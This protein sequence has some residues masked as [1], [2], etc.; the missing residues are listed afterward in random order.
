MPKAKNPRHGS[1]QVW[2]RKRAS[3]QYGRVRSWKI[4]GE[5][6][7]GFAG[8]KAGMTHVIATDADKHSLTKGEDIF[9]PATILECP[10][11]K[12][13]SVRS[14]TQ[15]FYGLHVANEV[16]VGK[17]K[18]LARKIGT[19]KAHD[20]KALDKLVT[21]EAK[22]LTVL[23][24]THP[25]ATGIG[26]KKPEL[27]EM[28]LAGDPAQQLAFVKEHA[29]AGIKASDVF[30]EGDYVDAHAV[31]QGKGFQG[32]VKRFGIAIR[33]HKSEKTK[34][35]PGS[36]GGWSAQQHV[37]YRV[38][39]A[40]QMGYH[41]RTQY[42]NQILKISTDASL[43]NPKGGF[44]NYGVVKN[45]YLIMKGSMPGPKKRLIRLV[46]PIRLDRVRTP[47]T[48]QEISTRSQQRR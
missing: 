39:H 41:L 1:M 5:G 11:L 28:H 7:L 27:F 4:Q 13:Y 9:I 21:P 24:F 36:L 45:E 3:R 31:T 6:L 47:P 33:S 26:K 38:A 16:V 15:D 2:P 8:Y 30:K 14:Y 43:V 18:E 37:M 23:V 25:G 32:P 22:F 17:E 20:A 10:P 12:I 46:K 42:N 44:V 35:G 19:K 40:G 48:I 29:A 34:R